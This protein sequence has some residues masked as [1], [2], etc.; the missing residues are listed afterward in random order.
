MHENFLKAGSFAKRRY[1]TT[2]LLRTKSYYYCNPLRKERGHEEFLAHI[3]RHTK[4]GVT[5]CEEFLWLY[6]FTEGLLINDF[7]CFKNANI[8]FARAL[9]SKCVYNARML[10]SK[11]CFSISLISASSPPLSPNLPRPASRSWEAYGLRDRPL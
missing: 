2:K 7:D 3:F 4:E 10:S 9:S 5:N 6:S 1:V 11:A 8:S